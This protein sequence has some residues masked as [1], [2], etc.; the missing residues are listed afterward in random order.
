MPLR[1]KCIKNLS[2]GRIYWSS[3]RFDSCG[4]YGLMIFRDSDIL[5][6]DRLAEGN[7]YSIIPCL[8]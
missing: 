8:K 6:I 2:A 1:L 5:K 4:K 7:H 3:T